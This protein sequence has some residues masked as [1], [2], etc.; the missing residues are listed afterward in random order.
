MI[1]LAIPL[2]AESTRIATESANQS[3]VSSVAH[4]WAAAHHWQVV[5]VD[6]AASGVRVRAIGPLPIPEPATFR[7]ALDARGLRSV[8]VQLEL[9]PSEIS[10]LPGT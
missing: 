6:A 7:A 5:A 10:D 3:D 8:D 4:E 1:V 2:G 9:T